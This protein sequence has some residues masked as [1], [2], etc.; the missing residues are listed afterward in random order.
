MAIKPKDE[1][2]TTANLAGVSAPYGMKIVRRSGVPNVSKPYGEP[3]LFVMAAAKSA[4]NDEEFEEV[5]RPRGDEWVYYDD[6]TGAQKAVSKDRHQVW[7]MQRRDRTA[8]KSA[9]KAHRSERERQKRSLK[10]QTASPTRDNDSKKEI[11]L[12]NLVG[13]ALKEGST[14]ISYMFEQDPASSDTLLWE[15]FIAKLSKEA[16]MSDA[17]LKGILQNMAKTEAKLLGDAV[18]KIADVLKSTGKFDVQPLGAGS[19]PETGE[20]NLNFVVIMKESEV[21]LRFA[22]G[23]ENNLPLIIFPDETREALNGLVTDDAKTLRAEL[24]HAQETVL[25]EMDE[26]LSLAMK[27]DEYLNSVKEGTEKTLEGMGLL[28][29]AMMKYLLKVKYRGVK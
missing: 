10:V 23:L 8:R 27:R 18:K 28:G 29:I 9:H 17:K 22:V 3:D 12:R 7:K 25:K 1:S 16:I 4:M 2:S 19:N 21:K 13:H 11:L 6:E 20:I 5:V 14:M 26:V 24:A 15:Q